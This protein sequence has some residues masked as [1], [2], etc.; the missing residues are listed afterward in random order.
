VRGLPQQF[1]TIAYILR[2][3][4]QTIRD[5]WLASASDLVT[6]IPAG[7]EHGGCRLERVLTHLVQRKGST[8][9]SR[10]LHAPSVIVAIPDQSPGG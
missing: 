10:F 9:L 4:I 8:S 6:N 7:G 3:E 2:Q 1:V 5:T